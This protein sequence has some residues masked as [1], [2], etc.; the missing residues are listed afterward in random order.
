M[1]TWHVLTGEFPPQPGGVS[2]YTGQLC[3]ALAERGH[4]V[5]VWAPG[6]DDS[7][8]RTGARAGDALAD[9]TPRADDAATGTG[10]CSDGLVTLHRLRHGF[11]PRGLNA[12]RRSIPRE[13]RVLVQYVPTAF[14]LRG[15]NLP[16][17]AW[18]ATRRPWVMFHEVAYPFGQG[19]ARTNVLAA[20]NTA[21]VVTLLARADAVLTST[22]A[23][24][25]KLRA[26]SPRRSDV[27]VVPV[28]S[29]L[30]T[31]VTPQRRRA[32]RRAL[33][34]SEDALV[35]GHF[36][37]YGAHVRPLIEAVLPRLV[38]RAP[39]M[40]LGRG[41]QTIAQRDGV[42]VPR[43]SEPEAIAA[44]L[45]ACDLLIQPFPDGATTRRTSLMAGLAL[46]VPTVTNRGFL[47]EPDWAALRPV[48]LAADASPS[49]LLETA[50][51]F[52]DSPALRTELGQRGAQVYRSHFSLEHL[53]QVLESLDR[54]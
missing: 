8:A 32:V 30:P 37:T 52:L 12:L 33:E 38:K 35:V 45:A 16:F 4:L 13:E 7:A 42:L 28:P 21:M 20:V 25:P 15:M 34:L 48:A 11:R 27:H 26:L 18:V 10:R 49:A 51:P 23:W 44:H 3:R 41:N 47:T 14:G 6:T 19:R 5:H 31:A 46:G 24:V 50:G 22:S 17:C 54:R 36:G 29:N 39:V 43:A 2:D 53:L 40:L 1:A 9:A